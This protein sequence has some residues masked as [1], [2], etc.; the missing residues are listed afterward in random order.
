MALIDGPLIDVPEEDGWQDDLGGRI[1]IVL[2]A[3][4]MFGTGFR[5]WTGVAETASL[6]TALPSFILFAVGCELLIIA[7]TG[8]DLERWGRHIAIGTVLL[9][10][11][12]TIAT[13]FATGSEWINRLN[14][15]AL[16]FSSYSVEL[17]AN[18]QNPY[19]HSMGPGRDLFGTG[20]FWTRRVDGS[21]VESLSY[22]G[23]AVLAFLPQF[24]LI[25]RGPIGIRLTLL[26]FVGVL[27]VLLAWMLPAQY[28]AAAPVSMLAT[29]N[30]W[31]TASGGVIEALWLVPFVA[32]LWAWANDRWLLAAVGLGLAAGTKQF[33]W[34]T[35]PFLAIWAYRERGL[36]SVGRMLTVGT[37]AFLALNLPFM[38]SAPVE[39]MYGVFTPLAPASAPLVV[40]GSG[41]AALFMAGVEIPRWGFT[42]AVATVSLTLLIAY[43]LRFEKLRWMAWIVPPCILLFHS[44]S[45]L[46]YFRAFIPVAVIAATAYKGRLRGLVRP[47]LTATTTEEVDPA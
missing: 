22:P 40:E 41:L 35:L 16:T 37:V 43:W 15:D 20:E 42:L 3:A 11:G 17:V 44:R 5:F 28:A 18:G 9:L 26:I 32:A 30:F 24:L 4:F 2:L 12:I 29:R 7:V 33:V 6:T 27:G 31:L 1:M 38:F 23:G 10:T 25:G 19:A 34:L 8:V 21:I 36:S 13:L 46:S 14:T 39:W 45:L 47:S